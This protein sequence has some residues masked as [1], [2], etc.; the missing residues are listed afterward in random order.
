MEII[1]NFLEYNNKKIFYREYGKVE[2]TSLIIILHGWTARGAISWED[3]IQKF[4]SDR[5]YIL[6]PDLPGLGNSD[7]PENV[8]SAED[9]ADFILGFMKD[10][11]SMDSY[12]NVTLVG[13][14]FG[15]AVAGWMAIKDRG[16]QNLVLCAPAIVRNRQ[17]STS[18]K[19]IEQ[20]TK[21]G[22]N[23]MKLPLLNQFKA[24]FKKIWY[25]S[26]GSKDY[27][28]VEG[29]MKEVMEK[30]IREDLQFY[31]PKIKQNT[32]IFWGENDKMTPIADAKK[33]KS[34]LTNSELVTFPE[35]NHGLHLYVAKEIHRK[36]IQK[37][38]A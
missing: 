16:I 21:I 19:T 26:F 15:G 32:L 6:A 14:S 31:L 27:Y 38:Y 12:N 35:V 10:I 5:F 37:F 20:I 17:K 9:F 18:Q 8:W 23:S 7:F 33:V 29:I 11:F 22:N 28:Q 30:I 4:D 36:I 34:G 1:S 3:F 2:S 13:H 24:F 25:S